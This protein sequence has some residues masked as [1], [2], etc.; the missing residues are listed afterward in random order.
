MKKYTKPI[1]REEYIVRAVRD[2]YPDLRNVKE[3][4]PNLQ[5]AVKLGKRCHEQL[6][7]SE[8]ACEINV[9][10][11]K[12]KYCKSEAGKRATIPD[13]REALFDCFFNI[14]TTLKARSPR[15]MLKLNVK[16]FMTNGWPNHTRK[17]FRGNGSCFQTAG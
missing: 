12:S 9:G 1:P 5:A 16:S 13:V 11:S 2:F 14:R 4:D 7:N 17:S 15:K 6:L 8:T 3:N 10:P